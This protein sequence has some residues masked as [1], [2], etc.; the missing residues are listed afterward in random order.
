MR[1]KSYGN[2]LALDGAIQATEKDEFAYQEMCTFLPLNSHPNPEKVATRSCS[3]P[4]LAIY[5]L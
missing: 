1:R 4:L 3:C 2:V 5:P